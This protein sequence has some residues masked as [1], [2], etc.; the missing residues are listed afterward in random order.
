MDYRTECDIIADWY[1][2][3]GDIEAVAEDYGIGIDEVES[4]LFSHGIALDTYRNE[5]DA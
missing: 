2:S 3:G 4:V 5:E 1:N